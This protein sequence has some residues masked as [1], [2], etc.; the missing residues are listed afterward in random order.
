MSRTHYEQL[1]HNDLVEVDVKDT[2]PAE[3][4]QQ[5]PWKRV[6]LVYAV[7][8][9]DAIGLM[10]ATPF[11]PALCESFGMS[12]NEVGAAAGMLI[13]GYSFANFFSSFYLGH[14]S[15][16]YGRRPLILLGLASTLVTTASFGF[17]TS[18]LIAFANRLFVG[19]CD[20]NISVSKAYLS[21]VVP[22]VD[23]AVVFAYFGAIFA[24][25]RAF[26]SALAG[27]LT[28]FSFNFGPFVR[29]PFAFPCLLGSIPLLVTFILSILYLPESNQSVLRSVNNKEVTDQ[30][31]KRGGSLV[32]GIRAMW[33]NRVLMRLFVVNCVHGFGNGSILLALVLL[34]TLP[35]HLRGL[36]FGTMEV[37]VAYTYFGLAGCAYQF[38]FFNRA[39]KRIGLLHLYLTGLLASVIGCLM[40]PL[41]ALPFYFGGTTGW[42]GVLTWSILLL[43]TTFIAIGFM[44]GLPIVST[45]LSNA[46]DP[47]IQGL[48][49]GTAQSFGSLIRALGPMASG[50]MF[51][52]S[53]SLNFP[54]LLFIV[55]AVT[56]GLCLLTAYPLPVSVEQPR[57]LLSPL[58]E[59]PYVNKH[60][61]SSGRADSPEPTP[62]TMKAGMAEI[63]RHS[64]PDTAPPPKLPASTK[65]I[66][67]HSAKVVMD[68]AMDTAVT[69]NVADSAHHHK[70]TAAMPPSTSP[71]RKSGTV[72]E[73]P[74]KPPPMLPDLR[75]VTPRFVATPTSAPPS[76]PVQPIHTPKGHE[77]T[78]FPGG[79]EADSCNNRT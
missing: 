76:L 73:Y 6:I 42:T 67:S 78:R 20:N 43:A 72:C 77:R 74:P 36:G 10:F 71:T 55:L 4:T 5:I 15:D 69:C 79:F 14:L 8:G 34:P 61:M 64:N 22:P 38:I 51:S 62:F 63:L 48:T 7:V 46:A 17:S 57:E 53:L 19:T 68:T 50:V 11:L 58:L 49:Q 52:M 33:T 29:F 66:T 59:L 45:M 16:R 75:P 26:S 54:E 9:F 56:Y 41:S 44:C 12:Q 31:K 27:L 23:R 3:K 35:K 24:L 70:T 65:P 30:L 13:S 28:G 1:E 21:D 40:Y 37:G 25:S 60:D 2:K 32:E 47:E 18:F 39:L